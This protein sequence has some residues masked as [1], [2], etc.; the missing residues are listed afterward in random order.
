MDVEKINCELV[1]WNQ[2]DCDRIQWRAVMDP[3]ALV[4]IIVIFKPCDWLSVY[5]TAPVP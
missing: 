2:L 5:D 4:I 3:R 1:D